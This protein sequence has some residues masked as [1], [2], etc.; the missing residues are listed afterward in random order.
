ML[1]TDTLIYTIKKRPGNLREA[2]ILHEGRMCISAVTW[3]E[4]VFG[5]EH[6]QQTERNLADIEAMA[7]RLEVMPFDS[8]AAAHFGQIRSELYSIGKPIGPYDMMIA[9]HARALGL[10]LVTNNTKEFERVRGLRLENWVVS[11]VSM[12]TSINK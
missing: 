9:G 1:D 8:K 3:G 12:G 4:L 5:A 7:S 10:I 11:M 2:F 6:S